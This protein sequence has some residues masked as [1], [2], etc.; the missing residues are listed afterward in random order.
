MV[1][2][3]AL[4]LPI[5]LLRVIWLDSVF[6]G[7]GR[8]CHQAF[9]FVFR[10]GANPLAVIIDSKIVPPKALVPLADQVLTHYA[11]RHLWL[12]GFLLI[13]PGCHTS[14]G[15]EQGNAPFLPVDL[16]IIVAQSK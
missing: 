16:A 3:L 1:L 8:R 9:R 4:F 15:G 2:F 11:T 7:F 12:S 14:F 6:R 13:L 10:A 5:V